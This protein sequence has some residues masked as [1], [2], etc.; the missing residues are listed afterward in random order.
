MR[1][2]ESS[3]P[4]TS[5]ASTYLHMFDDFI[6][7]YNENVV[8]S[9]VAYRELSKDGTAGRSRDLRQAL[10]AATALF[11]VREHLPA[12]HSPS[13]ADIESLCPDYA[14]LGDLVNAT[15]HAA[16]TSATPHGAPLV[17]RASDLREHVTLIEY[18]DEAGSYSFA[19][20]EVIA[21][22]SDGSER[23]VL[24][25]LTNVLNFWEKWL[26][27]IGLLS[28]VRV[29]RYESNARFRTR[30]EC[31][32]MR[33]CFE[34]VQGRRFHQT[35]KLLRWNSGTGI[36]EPIDLSGAEVRASIYKPK[37]AVDVTLTHDESGRQF[38]TSID[39]TDDES[40]TLSQL[41]TE[42]EKS[43]YAMALP[44][45]QLALARLAREAGLATARPEGGRQRH[46]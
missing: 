7:Y 23:N 31:E 38:T 29:F 45:A 8:D 11:H 40:A 22:L 26:H 27:G 39:L 33:P 15:K 30:E 41:R 19:Q 2:L 13:R 5:T 32:S 3:L 6:A 34:I 24:D 44:A 25:V 9:Y 46:D 21:F 36:V 42:E 16:I 37:Y 1:V 28:E 10:V 20:K 17:A 4:A 35:M 18:S 14:L 12:P 43:K